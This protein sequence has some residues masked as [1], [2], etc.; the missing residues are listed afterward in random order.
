MICQLS[1]VTRSGRYGPVSVCSDLTALGRPCSQL[2]KPP[3]PVRPIRPH[4]GPSSC[5]SSPRMGHSPPQPLLHSITFLIAP[6]TGQGP[7]CPVNAP[8]SPL[9]PQMPQPIPTCLAS[10]EWAPAGDATRS[11][12]R[13]CGCDISPPPQL[14]SPSRK[15]EWLGLRL[16]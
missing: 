9:S 4:L 1:P 16:R 7:G 14:G 10:E 11:S 15:E 8:S 2:A 12:Y 6:D 5:S 13:V 3:A